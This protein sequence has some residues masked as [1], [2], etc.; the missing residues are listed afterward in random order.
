M[1]AKLSLK[2]LQQQINVMTEEVKEVN[3]KL[4]DV[5]NELN[6]VKEELKLLKDKETV[7]TTEE[8]NFNCQICDETFTTKQNLKSHMRST[9]SDTTKIKCKFCDNVFEKNSDLENHIKRNH[10]SMEKFDCNKCDKKFALKWRLRKHQEIH[11]KMNIKKCHYY[12]NQKSCPFELIGCMFEHSLA[13]K[14]KFG[15][16]CKNQLCS[17]EHENE[18]FKCED[19]DFVCKTE[20]ELGAHIDEHEEWRVTSSFCDNF[21]RT[22]HGIDICRSSEEF[23]EYLGFDIW[24][25]RTTMESDSVYKCLKCDKIYDDSDEMKKHIQEKHEHEKTSPCNF[26]DYESKSWLDLKKHFKNNH[27]TED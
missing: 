17:Y 9:H 11:E 21:C 27:M 13:G 7:E 14:C 4:A 1:T 10:D 19:C 20:T 8:N 26:C 23:K 3:S 5:E 2:S 22:E 15:K 12:N 25:T 6:H 24:K 16:M 18:N